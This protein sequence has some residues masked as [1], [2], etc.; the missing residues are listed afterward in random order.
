MNDANTNPKDITRAV[1]L[2]TQALNTQDFLLALRGGEQQEAL[3]L[4]LLNEKIDQ[5]L[6]KL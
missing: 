6:D 2:S 5:V 1:L 3:A 4:A